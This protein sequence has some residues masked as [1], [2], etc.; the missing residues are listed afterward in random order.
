VHPIQ[1]PVDGR[2]LAVHWRLGQE[3]KAGDVL[4]ELESGEQRYLLEEERARG[5]ALGGQVEAL[6]RQIAAV[7]QALGEGRLGAR[8]ALAES[9]AHAAEATAGR[10]QGP[11]RGSRPC[12][13]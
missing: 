9:E 6:R 12:R 4:V 8:A 13:L 1:V 10:R 3:V 2:I 11:R 5:T 7:R